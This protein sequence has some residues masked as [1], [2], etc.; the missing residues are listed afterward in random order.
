MV[1]EGT[2]RELVGLV[3]ERDRVIL[4]ASGELTTYAEECRRL[5]RVD[6][7]DVGGEGGGTT[8]QLLVSDAR[9]LLPE[10]LDLAHRVDVQIRGVEIVE[11]DLEAVFLHLTGT[12]L[13]E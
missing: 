9:S 12:A 2:Q 5:E 10:L 6:H 7:A 1:A 4:T 11:P 8:V 13:R 3:A